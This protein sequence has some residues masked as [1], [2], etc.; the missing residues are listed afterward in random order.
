MSDKFSPENQDKMALDLFKSKMGDCL[1]L[2][3]KL[4]RT[5]A[6]LPVLYPR[7]GDKRY[8]ERGESYYEERAGNTAIITPSRFEKA[9]KSCGCNMTKLRPKI[10]KY[11]SPECILTQDEEKLYNDNI[12]NDSDAKDFRWWVHQDSQR[13]KKVNDGLNE[14]GYGDGLDLGFGKN[15]YT[16]IAF[17]LVG[18]K[19]VDEGK[20][21]KPNVGDIKRGLPKANFDKI[22]N[23][24]NYRSGQLTLSELK[25]VI[26]NYGIKN[27]VR[28]NGD[29][30][31]GGESDGK[32]KSNDEEVLRSEEKELAESLGVNYQTIFAHQGYVDGEGYVTST[33]KIQPILNKGNTLIHC[34]NGSDR[35]GGQVGKYLLDNGYGEICRNFCPQ[36]N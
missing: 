12:K 21:K 25:Y 14:C 35:T 13:I 9:L 29:S 28:M 15:E 31:K 10:N 2:E 19:W 24:T 18:K 27:I 11:I 33:E 4:V 3:D 34:R 20:P 36:Y 16:E 32:A 30:E 22:P 8:V 7:Q 5:W 6:G 23:S 1:E 26:E 17:K